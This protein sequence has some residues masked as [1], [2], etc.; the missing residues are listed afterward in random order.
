MEGHAAR[1]TSRQGGNDVFLMFV[2]GYPPAVVDSASGAWF[3]V[4]E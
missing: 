3:V 1:A 2:I 4:I